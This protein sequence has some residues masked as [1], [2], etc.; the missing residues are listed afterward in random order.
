M[1]TNIK[2]IY[3]MKKADNNIDIFALTDSHQET[4]KL[5]CLFSKIIEEAPENGK[6][7]LICDCGDLFKGIYKRELSIESYE[8]LRRQLP[9]AK[10]V[11]AVGNNDFGF[12][13]ESFKF[14]QSA[15][16][17]FNQANIHV[18]CANLLDI[19]T[20]RC[21]S[22]VDPYILLEINHK[23]V[24][25][26][27]FCINQV[28]LSKYGVVLTDIPETFAAMS[29]VIKHIEPDALIVLNHDL[30]QCSHD[31]YQTSLKCGIRVDLLLGGHEH[32]PI[33][34][35]TEERMYYPQAY[36]KTMLHFNLEFLKQSTK[37][38]LQEEINV[39]QTVINQVFEPHLIEFEEAS[40]LNIPVA[41]S[42]LNLEKIY[43]DPCSLGT[44]IADC[45]RMAAK[46]EI[47]MIST[48]YTSHALRYEKDKILTH[49]NLER[50]F[51]ADV[52]LQTVV[53]T[54]Q[55]LK[56]VFDNAVKYRYLIP[57]GNVR[58][59][60]CSQNVEICCRRRENNE[61]EVTQIYIGSEPLLK[62][63][64]T[65][66]YED[67]VISC[68]LDPFIGAGEQGFDVLRQL[69]KETLLKN[70]HLVKIK[71]LFNNAIK[72]AEHKYPA[73]SLYPSFKVVDED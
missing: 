37:L 11:L 72:E 39:K 49:Y 57:T 62:E 47:A 48:G 58:F 69:P 27:A 24:M 73:G 6:N 54:P 53:L 17:R 35:N 60:Q 23:K 43:S 12:N 50:A 15:A 46:T 51:S 3:G 8:I 55:E 63:D 26:T 40:G 38:K 52:P 34:P 28:R 21:P 71:D 20:G 64:G 14:L 25:V 59:L 66:V 9:E 4:R 65:A 1:L 44:F 33:V 32:S 41:K 10:I 56:E 68:A 5:C 31:I 7:T 16:K 70:N 22:W 29:E 61:G 45:M 19:N 36:S 13:L 67:K 30:E 2:K 42:T 18:L